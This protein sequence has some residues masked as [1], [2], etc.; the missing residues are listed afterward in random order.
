MKV[1]MIRPVALRWAAMLSATVLV[2]GSTVER[3]VTA[4][5]PMASTNGYGDCHE[6]P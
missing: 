6:M 4:S 1:D 3:A 2:V 5:W